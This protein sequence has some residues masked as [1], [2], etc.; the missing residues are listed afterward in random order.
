MS[1]NSLARL[2]Q[3]RGFVPDRLLFMTYVFN[4]RDFHDQVLRRLIENASGRRLRVDVIASCVDVEEESDCFDYRYLAPLGN[5]FRLFRCTDRPLVHAKAIIAQDSLTGKRLAG[6]GSANLTPGGW[7]HNVELWRWDNGR[8]VSAILRMCEIL[9]RSNGLNSGLAAAWRQ[10]F[11]PTKEDTSITLLGVPNAPSFQTVL[12]RLLRAV[13]NPRVVRVASPYF[14]ADSAD[15]FERIA[16]AAR[17]CRLEIWTDRSGK[18]AEPTYWRVLS[19]LLPKLSRIFEDVSVIAPKA[20]PWHAK[21]LELDDGR[22]RVARVFGSANFTGAAWGLKRPGNVELIATETRA[23]GL[24]DM[25]A[26]RSPCRQSWP[27]NADVSIGRR[28][29]SS[30]PELAARSCYGPAW[31]RSRRS[32]SALGLLVLS[33]L[34]GGA[35]KDISMKAAQTM[36]RIDSERFE[37]E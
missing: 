17:R 20:A 23:I 8:S 24:P 33:E 26:P 32:R 37:T 7:R 19:A 18:L 25:L 6:F 16:R 12:E 29:K 4:F 34:H 36:R 15:L 1:S 11:G 10:A 27:R 35:W 21:V 3:S 14:D 13:A 2:W 28:S 5:G 9:E 31:Q 30:L 22:G